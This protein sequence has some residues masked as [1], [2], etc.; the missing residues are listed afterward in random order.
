MAFNQI[1]RN[2]SAAGLAI[3]ESAWK[4][5]LPDLIVVS[6]TDRSMAKPSA[7]LVARKPPG[8]FCLTFMFLIALSGPLR[9]RRPVIRARGEHRNLL[10]SQLVIIAEK[11]YCS[12]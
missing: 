12:Q 9:S 4:T 1:Y 3:K 7:P 10:S 8:S 11:C 2:Y 5:S 6:I